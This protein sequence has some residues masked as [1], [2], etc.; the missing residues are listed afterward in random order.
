[1]GHARVSWGFF[2]GSIR[3]CCVIQVFSRSCWVLQILS[4]ELTG[5]PVRMH[6]GN[7]EK[8][9]LCSLL[10]HWVKATSHGWSI[11]SLENVHFSHLL[12]E[13]DTVTFLILPSKTTPAQGPKQIRS[14]LEAVASF[15]SDRK[16]HAISVNSVSAWCHGVRSC[17]VLTL[18]Y[19]GG[20]NSY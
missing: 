12:V 16:H 6:Q 10:L 3:Y 13:A 9:L 14:G 19:I 5:S 15:F 17:P 1:M 11:S 2:T 4:L 20:L 7:D 8:G 18:L